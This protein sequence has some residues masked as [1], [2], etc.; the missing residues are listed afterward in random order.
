MKTK[1]L[2]DTTPFLHRIALIGGCFA[3]LGGVGAAHAAD[4]INGAKIYSTHCVNCHGA[5]GV[6]SMPGAPDFSRAER[7][8]QSDIALL[9]SIG[10]GKGVMPSYQGLLP[11]RDILDV[12]A[13]LR[14]L[15]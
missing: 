5:R 9:K 1:R 10:K 12:I 15:R 8:L 2:R 4:P 7:L 11:E 13:Y 14:T 6:P 3:L